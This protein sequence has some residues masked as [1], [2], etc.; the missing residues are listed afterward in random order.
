MLSRP[1]ILIAACLATQPVAAHAEL[2]D[3]ARTMIENAIATGDA[4]KVDAVI[5]VARSSF[6]SDAAEIDALESGW[7]TAKAERDAAAEE[8]RLAKIENAGMFELWKGEGELGGFQSSGNTDSVGIAAS[9]KLKREGIDWSHRLQARVDYQR[10]NG[11]TSRE[12]YLFSYEPRWQFNDRMFVY[13]LAQ[14]ESDKIQGFSGRYAA[15]G[16]VGYKLVDSGDVSLSIKAGPAYRV[17][18]YTDGRT[19]SRIA[20][21]A[22]LDFDWKIFERLTFS[23]DANALAETG[24]EAQLIVDGS[25]TSLTFVSGLD[26]KVTNRLR[27]RLS[28]QLD[29]DSNPPVGKVSTDTLT[30]ATLIYGF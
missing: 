13:A 29:Y 14:F 2:P 25:N 9:L 20:A 15:S 27:S 26:F 3:A 24:G 17:T 30:R 5:A 18:E 4:A 6:P 21:L 23:Q 7:K 28:Y 19:E 16:G 1:S 10:Q 22:G 8:A 11:T 12:Q